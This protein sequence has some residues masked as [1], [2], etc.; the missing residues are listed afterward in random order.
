M[1]ASVCKSSGL[2]MLGLDDEVRGWRG[3]AGGALHHV[4]LESAAIRG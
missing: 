3:A 1:P 2:E 4:M